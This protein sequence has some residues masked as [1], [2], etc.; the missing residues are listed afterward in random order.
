MNK[1]DTLYELLEKSC[2]DII[3]SEE[4]WLS[5]L[6]TSGYLYNFNFTNQLL[7][8]QQRPDA[9]ACTDFETWNNRMNRWIKKGSKGIAL[10]DDDGR[11]TKIRYVFDIADTRSPRNRELHLWSVQ[12]SFHKQ[13]I[14]KIAKQFDMTSNNEDLGSFIKEIA[15]EQTGYYVDDYFKRLMKLKDGSLLESY[16]ENELKNLYRNLLENSVAYSLMSR[17]DIETRFYFEA[18]DFISIELFN[19]PEMLGVIGNSFQEESNSLLNVISH[20]T[21]ELIIQNRTFE[22]NNRLVDDKIEKNE[23]SVINGTNHILNSGRLSNA[24]FDS[25]Q[26]DTFRKIRNDEEKISEGTATRNSLF[27]SS[28]ESTEL[29]LNGNREEGKR[30]DGNVDEG[31]VNEK[32][33]TEQRDTSDGMGTAYEQP[34]KNS[35]RNHS[36]GNNLQLDLGIEEVDKEK[37]GDNVLPPFDLS[38]LPQLLREDVSLQHSKEEIIQYFHEHTDEIERANYLK[39]CYDDTLVQTFR[40]PEHYDYSYLG[41]KKRNDGLDVWSGNY[42][43]MKSKSYL[44]FF[45]LQSYLAKIIEKDEYLTSPYEN[46]SGLKRAYENK[47]INANVFYHV[48]QYND[49]LLESAGK[50]IEFFQT[51]DS[52]EERCEYV[53]RIYPDSIREWKVD[54]V[55]LG[56]DRLDDGLHIYLGTFDNQV[57]SYDYSWNFVAK[58]IDG[59]ILSRYFAPDIQIP[60]LEEQKNAVYE[61]IQNFENGIFFSQQEIDR[62]LTRGSGFE[63]GKYRINQMFSKNTTLKEKVQ[64][65][66]KEYGEGGSSPAVG[67]INVNYDT[68]GMSLSRYREIGKDEIKITLKWDKVAKRIDELIQLDRY[69]NKKEKEYYPTFLQNQLQHQLEYERKSINQSL[70]PE[71]SDDLQNENIPK[72]YQWNLGDSVYVGATEYK[73]IESG[74]EITLQDE[75]FPLFLEYYSKDDFLKLLK[76]NP[77]NDHLLKTITQ[78]VQDINIDSSNHTIIK[79]YLPDLED[80]IKRSMIYPALRDS[81]TTDEEAEDYIREELISIMPSYETKDPDFYNRYL[82]DDDFRNSLVDYLIDRTYEDYSIS[83]D[84]FNKE[85]KENRQLFEKMKKIVPR[86]M[87]EISGFCNMITASDNDDPL[88]ILYDHDEKTIDMFHYYEVNGIE[89]SEPYMTF[90]VDFSKEVLEPISYKNDSID[91]EISSDTQ[92]KD[93]LSTKV[94]L[95]NYANQWLDRLLE[96]NY[97]VESEQ[98]FKDSINKR[99]IYHIDYDGSFIVYTDMP[100]SLVKEFA[101]NYNYI[102]SDK[103]QKEDILINPVQSEKINYQIMDKDLGKRT[104]KERYNDNVAAIRLLFSLEKQG[105]NAT[106]DEQNILSRYVGWGGLADA[107]DESKSNWANEHLELKSLLSEEEYKSARESTLTSFYT[108][109]VVIES[110]YKALNNLGFRHGNILEPSCGIGNFF[111]MLPDEM[112]DSK[113]YGVELDS[114]SGR[115]AKQ[116]YQNSNIAIEG[117]EET[118]LPD[119]FFDVAVGNVPFGNFKVVDKKYDRLNFNIHDYFFAKTIDKVRPNGIIAFVTSRYTMDKRNSNVRRYINERCELLGAIRLPND[120]FGDTKAV[121]DI[122]FLQKRERPVLKD[123]DWVSTGITEEGY[124]INQYYIDHPEM[125]LGTIEKTHAMYGREDITVVGYDEPLNEL[126]EKAIYNIKGH[127]DEVD[128]VEEN[129][130][131]IESIPADPQIRN[132]S[133]TVIGDKVYYRENSLMNKVDVGD[134]TFKRIKGMIRIRDTVR[135]LIT[136][137]SED[138]PEEMIA[139]KQ[140]ELNDYYDVFTQAYGLLNSRGNTIAFRE[141]SS[142]YLLCSLENLNEDG[143]LKSKAAMFT[144]RTIRKKKEFNNVATANEALMV[145]LSE[146]AKV[147][148]N[149]MS[150]LTGIS[151]E[152]IKG[153]LDGIIFKVPSV[154]NEEQEEY[155]TA[156]E[157]LS[158]NIREKLEVAKM[159]AAIDPKYQKNVEA[160]EKAMPKELT[161]SE[162]EVRLGATWIPVEIYQQFLYELLDTPSW[163]RNYTKLSYSSYNANWNISAKNMD[164]ESVK[165][166]KT[167]GTS[168]ANAYRLMED[169]LNLKQTKIFDYE[170]DD[171]GNKQAILNKKE[172]M[173]AQQKQDTIKESFNNWIWKDP[174]RREELTQIYNRLFNSIR[175]REYNGDHL[176][177]PG[178]NPEITLRKHQKDAIAH[179]LYGQN[180]LLA[181]VVGAGKTFEMTA[182]CMELKRLGLAQKPMFVVPN[183]LVEQWG[184]EFLQLYP[185]ANILVAT[186]RDFEKKNRKKLFSKMATGEY[187]AIIIGHSQFEKIPMSIERQKMNIENEIEE[188]T[189]GINSLKANNGERFTI[190]QLERTKKG[191]KAKLEKLNKN[192][193]KDDLITFEEIGVDRLFVD[194]AHF[195]KNL[196]LFTKMNNVSGLSTTDAQKSSDLYL[197]CRYL[198]EITGGKGVVFAT[199]TPISNSMTEMYTMQRYLQYSTLVKHNLQHFDCWASTFGETST[200]I[201]LA[202]EGSGYRMKTRFSKFFNLPELINMFKEVADIKTADMLNLPVPNAH[203][204]NVVVKP[205]DIQKELVESLG[206]RA[207]KIRDGTVDPHED[208]MLKIT[209]DGRKLALDQ[210][211]I[212]ELLPEN[213]NSKV[214]ACIKNILKIYH[215]TVEE[216]S[217]QLVFCDMSTPRN[218]A[219]NVYDEIKNKLLEEGIPESEIAYIHNA[220]TDAKKKELFSKVREGKVRILIGSTGKMGAG[221]NVQER[222]IAIHDLDCPWRPSD[223]EQRA[224]RIVRQG[225]RNKDVYIYRY[226]TEGTFDAYL[227]QLVENKQKFIGQ[228]MTS[229]SPVR[230]AEDIDEASLSYAEIKALAS[231]NPKVKE[232]MELDTKVSKLKLAK[233]NYLSQKYDLEDRI[234]K[235][236]PQKIKAIKTRIEGLENDIKDLKPQKE[237]QQIKIKDMLIVD[238]KQAGNTILLACKGYDGQDK[239]YI[240]EYRGFDLYIQFNSLSQYYIMSLKKELYYPVELGNDVYGNLTRIDNAIENIPKSLKVEKELL[241]NTL[242]QLHNAELEVEKPFEKEDE[243]NDALKKL[244]K[245]NKELDLDKKENIPDTSVQKNDTGIGRKSKVNRMR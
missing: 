66:K 88:M 64:F 138:Y 201:E 111:G 25:R 73:I 200:S 18:D 89:V 137:Q 46:E 223:L 9:K 80:Q 191:L 139:K 39:E 81:D 185:S 72:E 61:N 129:E 213:K 135:D 77:L 141:D 38:D 194:E 236:Y 151:D 210:R 149:Y 211:L 119:S 156:D 63:E 41:Y 62:V 117:Y 217:T 234:I 50:I 31:I 6:R 231:G 22:N 167:Y 97:I 121:S 204:Q 16:G 99:E 74:N 193:R 186:K 54:D 91:I 24:Q 93:V 118:K 30:D 106:K 51:H 152:K 95:E 171:D 172:T 216:K 143:T 75:S 188:I 53:Q 189:N 145:S 12:E 153:D 68:K 178:M 60:S 158:G 168:R 165:A 134:T 243:L 173:I 110:I 203:Y 45:Q 180:V 207:Q 224:G 240:G 206:E 5:F 102:V 220:K 71:S 166:D 155:V 13:L 48:F 120:A 8:Y 44:S 208:N 116:L 146:K 218:D 100:Y 59:M 4:S 184:A 108:S 55:I 122:L 105:R 98:V 107:F 154:L 187:D 161:A 241:Q 197:K 96:K 82:N 229:K 101:D 202:P 125:I 242:Q 126:L 2:H 212:N 15:K 113:M 29:L 162:I 179:I 78:E 169:C 233:A 32:S 21:K 11:Y 124:V 14:D 225:N 239:K 27:T 147:D 227:Y 37:G 49:E 232:K 103:I 34:S 43:N 198:D 190:K 17:C 58:E 140:R 52:D 84:I 128:I 87:N 57:V 195:Y 164:K 150:E 114:I 181:H 144:Q 130:N 10:I 36:E 83:N 221:T 40:C 192:D 86:I 90:K 109:P 148:I 196:F 104:P 115:I 23:G 219:F 228:I 42:L 177:F 142:F 56:Y 133:Y 3:Q 226:V 237:F 136:Y 205:S 127:I 65:L 176:E 20:I 1:L 245:I 70:I 157:Y 47:I 209:N 215:E 163:V 238:K 170:Y 112:K 174:Q 76:E 123:D 244:S 28:K 26:G 199:G 182:A 160:L 69:L 159:S 35:G 183:H 7:I 92:N 214:N 222:L 175:P 85:N 67:F 235:Y 33:S 19:T 94:D 132:Y 79:R 230:S 131:E